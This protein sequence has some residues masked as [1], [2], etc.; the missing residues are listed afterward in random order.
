[1]A[2]VRNLLDTEDVVFVAGFEYHVKLWDE[3]TFSTVTREKVCSCGEPKCAHIAAVT[4]YLRSG[5]RRP[6]DPVFLCPICGGKTVVDTQWLDRDDEGRKR[7]G[8]RCENGGLRHFLDAKAE[9]IKKRLAA[10]LWLFPPVYD[11]TGKCVYEGVRRD[12]VV[13]AEECGKISLKVFQ[14]TGYDPTA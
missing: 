7:Y 9:R 14:E 13:T 10:N 8:W 11:E 2:V 1:M 5:G 4:K 6:P 3:T 12:E